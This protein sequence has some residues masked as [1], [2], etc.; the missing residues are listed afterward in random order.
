MTFSAAGTSQ[1]PATR[2]PHESR[3]A[4]KFGFVAHHHDRLLLV[5]GLPP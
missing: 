2:P 4:E 1:L 3:V 5:G